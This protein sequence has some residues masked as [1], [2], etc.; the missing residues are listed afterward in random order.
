MTLGCRIDSLRFPLRDRDTKYTHTFDADFQ[1][2]DVEILLSPPR[3]PRANAICERVVATLRREI[4]DRT[5][6]YNQAH[7][8][9]VMTESNRHRPQQS[10]QQLPPDR[11]ESPAP[12]TV[13][14][15]Q[16]HGIRRRSVLGGLINEYHH[17]A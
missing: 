4:L 8:V 6:I 2:D 14:N 12:A 13:T 16:T 11:P 7:A 17:A 5:L 10:R 15:L 9:A 1:A 3:A